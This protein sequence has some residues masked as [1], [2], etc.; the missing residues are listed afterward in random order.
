M[1]ASLDNDNENI[2]T[3]LTERALFKKY[4][5]SAARYY[6]LTYKDL[7]IL[8]K[9]HKYDALEKILNKNIQPIVVRLISPVIVSDYAATNLK[10]YFAEVLSYY[11]SGQVKVMAK[12]QKDLAIS[13]INFFNK[14]P[15]N[16]EE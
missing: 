5:S 15:L 12:D 6:K 1:C 8:S 2:D 4:V 9:Q 16:L 10:E 3:H 11:L 7:T 14:L 13:T